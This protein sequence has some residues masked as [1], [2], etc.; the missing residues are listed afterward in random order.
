MLMHMMATLSKT[1]WKVFFN[2]LMRITL[3]G[4]FFFQETQGFI[5]KITHIS[6]TS[7]KG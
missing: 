3:C 1:G 2:I 6:D 4:V 5:A 7:Y